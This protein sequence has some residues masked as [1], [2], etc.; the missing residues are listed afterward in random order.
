MQSTDAYSKLSDHMRSCGIP[1]DQW[2]TVATCMT[3]WLTDVTKDYSNKSD[4]DALISEI[5]S[6]VPPSSFKDASSSLGTTQQAPQTT[7]TRSSP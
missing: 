6:Q 1:E 7:S 2:S 4:F 3:G 5:R